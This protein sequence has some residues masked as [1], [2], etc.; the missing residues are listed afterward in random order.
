[1]ALTH[2]D[3]ADDRALAPE[4]EGIDVVLG[5]HDHDPITFYEGGKLIVKAGLRPP[6]PRRDRPHRRPG[7]VKDREVVEVV[8]SWRFVSTAGVAPDPEIQTVVAR[9]ETT[10]STRSSPCR[11][12]HHGRARHAAQHRAHGRDQLRRPD[13]RC[14]PRATGA[15]VALT[16][17]GGIRGDRTYPAGTVLTRKDILTEL[18][19]GNVTVLIGSGADLLAALESGVSQVEDTPA[20]SPRCPA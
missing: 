11:W 6:L 12:A 7:P 15:D 18:P 14:H 16:N 2:Q 20:A 4:V 9:W 3:L 5:G 1:M 8:P 13:R 17:G 19:F 10:S